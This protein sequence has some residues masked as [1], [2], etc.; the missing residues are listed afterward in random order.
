MKNK[1][2]IIAITIVL[3]VMA[4]T[5]AFAQ[6][7]TLQLNGNTLQPAVA[8]VIEDGSTLVPLR[9]ISENMG[10]SVVWNGEDRSV[11]I[12]KDG[13]NIY[14]ILDQKTVNVNGE[15]K[16]LAVA[17]KIIDGSTMVPIRFVSEN[18]DCSVSWDGINRIVSIIE[19]GVVVEE[20]KPTTVSQPTVQKEPVYTND[21]KHQVIDDENFIVYYTPKGEK[22]HATKDCPT[23]ARSKTINETTLG[24]AT[25]SFR[26]A[27]DKCN[28]PILNI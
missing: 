12:E 22:Y 9:I 24:E 2:K 3:F 10:A 19:S 25:D 23:L 6:D 18:L 15:T 8:P 17:S 14:L 4:A 16:E 20:S 21:G 26:D 7:I 13:T 11:T 27:C 28:A 1:I 5:P